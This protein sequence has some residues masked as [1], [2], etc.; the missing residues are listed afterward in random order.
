MLAL[1]TAVFLSYN[2]V[3]KYNLNKSVF[4]QKQ[5]LPNFQFYNQEATLFSSRDLKENMGICI[6]YYNAECEHCQYEA[7]QISKNVSAFKDTQV[8]MVSTNTP[9]ETAAFA[10]SYKLDLAG[11]T[12]LYDKEYSFYRWFGKSST[13]SVYIYNAEHRLVKEYNGEVKIEAV[14]KYLGNGKEG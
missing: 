3:K 4:L 13:P 7:V 1:S 6:F 12:W 11:F 5:R 9:R 2:I 10:K 14:I 8:V